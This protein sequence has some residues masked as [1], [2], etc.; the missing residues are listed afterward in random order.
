MLVTASL[1]QAI[2]GPCSGYYATYHANMTLMQFLCLLLFCLQLWF[3][4]YFVAS[5]ILI[6]VYALYAGVVTR[7]D[8]TSSVFPQ[9]SIMFMQSLLLFMFWLNM[10][11]MEDQLVPLNKV[12]ENSPES[13]KVSLLQTQHWLQARQYSSAAV[14]VH[15]RPIQLPS[16]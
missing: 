4:S 16:S 8:K 9:W 10:V 15:L 3:F 7:N 1:P 6:N 5:F 13:A 2:S 11:S 14:P 12:I